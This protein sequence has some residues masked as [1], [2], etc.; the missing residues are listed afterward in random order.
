[1]NRAT[2]H[3]NDAEAFRAFCEA[4][5]W[6][7][8]PAKGPFEVMRLR[9]PVHLRKPQQAPQIVFARQTGAQLSVH[10]SFM[11]TVRRFI[12]AKRAAR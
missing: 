6:T 7:S 9:Q 5:G 2:L 11:P 8:E 3:R 10:E 12:A 1:V 4:E